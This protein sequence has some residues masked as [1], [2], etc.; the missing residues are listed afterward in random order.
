MVLS[1][2]QTESDIGENFHWDFEHNE[3]NFNM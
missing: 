3:L 1:K 2:L